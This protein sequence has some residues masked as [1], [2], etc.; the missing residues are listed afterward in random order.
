MVVFSSQKGMFILSPEGFS[1]FSQKEVF[2][3]NQL[4]SIYYDKFEGCLF[5]GTASRGLLKLIR[6]RC[7]SEFD[8]DPE[9]QY[10]FGAMAMLP[11]GRTAVNADRSIVI[12]PEKR[13]IRVGNPGSYHSGLSLFG[14]T[15]AVLD[16]DGTISAFSLR[17]QRELFQ[18]HFVKSP[19]FA[20]FRDRSG[21]FWTGTGNG[22]YRGKDLLQGSR[23]FDHQI[24]NKVTTLYEDSKQTLWVGG[25][26]G[27]FVLD[28]NR[29][30]EMRF[31]IGAMTSAQ[32]VRAFYES[33]AGTIWIGTYGAGLFCYENGRMIALKEKENY[34]LGSD[35]FTLARD[36]LGYI[37][38]SSNNGIRVVHE[39]VLN[40]YANG[41][42]PYLV[43]FYV[44]EHSGIFNPEF[45][46]GFLNNY[47][48]YK[49]SV[50]YFP[51]IQGYVR[52][53]SRT[54]PQ[55]TDNLRIDQVTLDGTPADMPFRIS[56]KVKFIRFDF[57]DANFSE[58][59]NLFYQYRLQDKNGKGNWSKLQK[60]PFVTF[61]NLGPGKYQ[62]QVR[63]IDGFNPPDPISVS[64]DFYIPP[65]FYE[66]FFFYIFLLIGTLILLIVHL[67]RKF[68][69]QKKEIARELELKNALTEM[70]L[71]AVQSQMN[72][73]FL[74][75]SLNT[76]VN[77]ISANYLDKAEKF[78]IDLSQLFR[79]ILEQSG[80]N[81]ILVQQEIGTL[82]KYMEIQQA[83]F[84]FDFSIHC[85]HELR[86]RKIPTMLLQPLV[87][88]AIIHGI[89][90]LV[91]EKG[92]ITIDF[93]AR[94]KETIQIDIQDN[95]VGFNKSAEIYKGKKKKSMGMEMINRKI[96]LLYDRYNTVVMIEKGNS[97]HTAQRGAHIKLIIK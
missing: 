53:V 27:V 61:S 13:E 93:S 69:K 36:K 72:P 3:S 85:P 64:Y 81:F 52:Y 31:D 58:T 57:F 38:M 91:G 86:D 55:R 66:S 47:C 95:G 63:A 73:H 65:F 2:P 18:A 9:F 43:P 40:N 50:F 42:I 84:D 97:D 20:V 71:I 68:G 62:F 12:F 32:D 33:A 49:D 11:D 87:E 75:N 39:Q 90:H 10:S 22:L 59:Q 54:F 14:D 7:W 29:K 89:A 37:L 23:A 96:A 41:K 8:D 78:A 4:T 5:V 34:L 92:K 28:K 30:L 51:G 45:N 17:Q 76:L 70:Q 25:S 48:S 24:K 80:K 77:M 88:N 21:T 26:E 60:E 94:E 6:R 74:F 83:R 19:V 46:G 79:R 56:R 44:G 82:V 1:F 15:L 35:I 16:W 67:E